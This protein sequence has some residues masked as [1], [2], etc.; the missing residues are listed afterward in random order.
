MKRA[1]GGGG[2]SGVLAEVHGE[3]QGRVHRLLWRGSSVS[4]GSPA[5]E[6]L[7]GGAQSAGCR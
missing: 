2:W 1:V 4:H 6:L 3:L 7:R 5:S